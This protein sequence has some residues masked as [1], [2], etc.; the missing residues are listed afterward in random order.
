MPS[1]ICGYYHVHHVTVL[2]CMRVFTQKIATAL[3]DLA[4][5]NKKKDP[6]KQGEKVDQLNFEQYLRSIRTKLTIENLQAVF[7][8]TT[9]QSGR[10][11]SASLNYDQVRSSCW[12]CGKIKSPPSQKK[13]NIHIVSLCFTLR[14]NNPICYFACIILL[15]Q[16]WARM[17]TYSTPQSP[18]VPHR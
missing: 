13:T 3:L 2:Y 5:L 4:D 10:E 17:M 12:L 14:S 1:G 9:Y 8:M 15:L 18:F 7:F 6:E 11:K 16:H